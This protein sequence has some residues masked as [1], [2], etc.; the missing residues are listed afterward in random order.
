M[1]R[2]IDDPA[3][4]LYNIQLPAAQFY[5]NALG[6]QSAEPIESCLFCME[7]FAFTRAFEKLKSVYIA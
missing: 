3:V 4:L 5:W 1:Q 2:A 7:Y 6:F